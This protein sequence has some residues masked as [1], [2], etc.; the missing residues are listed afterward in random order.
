MTTQQYIT[1]HNL[2]KLS[3]GIYVKP[4]DIPGRYVTATEIK[5]IVNYKMIKIC[6]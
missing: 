3:E 4:G 6:K 5:L 2:K 1:F